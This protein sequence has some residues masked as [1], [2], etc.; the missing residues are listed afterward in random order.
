VGVSDE[1]QLRCYWLLMM[2]FIILLMGVFVLS[3]LP[4]SLPCDHFAVSPYISVSPA[5]SRVDDASTARLLPCSLFGMRVVAR[6]CHGLLFV[7]P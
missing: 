1:R 6:V 2:L 3:P 7:C 5:A 4:L